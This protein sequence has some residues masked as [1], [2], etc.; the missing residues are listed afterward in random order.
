MTENHIDKSLAFAFLNDLRKKFL[1]TFDYDK[2]AIAIAHQFK[3]FNPSIAQLINYYNT[4]PQLTKTGE[5]IKELNEA[6]EVMVENIEKLLQRQDMMN[7]VVL[8]S[9]GLVTKAEGVNHY[10]PSF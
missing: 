4:N 7:I 2:V 8:K 5:I 1:Q 10:V 9:E 3:D 6:K